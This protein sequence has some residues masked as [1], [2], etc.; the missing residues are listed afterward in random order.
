MDFRIRG[1]K[2]T[3]RYSRWMKKRW[4][5][6]V[7]SRREIVISSVKNKTEYDHLDS[8]L[9]E[10][11]HAEFPD[12]KESVVHHGATDI[13]WALWKIGYRKK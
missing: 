7:Y 9:H 8:A 1:E 2:W 3:L 11:L 5:W 12:L 13:A 4:G 10:L 6:C